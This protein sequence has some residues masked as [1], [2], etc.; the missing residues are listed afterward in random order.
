[1]ENKKIAIIDPV[2]S[3]AG[4]NYYDIGLLS[5]LQKLNIQTY[6][7]SNFSNAG[8]GIICHNI[9]DSFI[10]NK[11]KKGI[12]QLLAHFKAYRICR[13]ENIQWVI[14][15][16]FSV[17][18]S[19]LI[20][21]FLSRLFNFK[22][23]LIA[24][25]VDSLAGDD[26][27]FF[28]KIIYKFLN[29]HVVVHNKYSSQKIS[30]IISAE[31]YSQIQQGAY[32]HLVNKKI[33]Q[34]L[35]KEKLGFDKNTHY[36]LFFGQI[37]KLKRLD[38]LI[39]SMSYVDKKIKLVI[40]GKPWKDDFSKYQKLIEENKLENKIIQQIGFVN[41]NDRELLMKASDAIIF[42]YEEVYQSAALLMGMSYGLA[43]IVSDI[44]PFK[45]II[46]ENKN[47]LFFK[48][49]DS[50]DLAKKI[51]FLFKDNNLLNQLK[52]GS[53]N[54][55]NSELSWDSIAFKYKKIFNLY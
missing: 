55:I 45:E 33:T 11:L 35:A 5:G 30:K 34:S 40:A 6:L 36:V 31:K 46:K 18:L 1:M 42:P 41:D 4:M 48:S 43:V 7:F 9:F 15:H 14:F 29:D 2:G 20:F 52:K 19:T 3:K 38:I 16:V 25:D 50:I 51:N 21:C 53:L 8:N 12:R 22:T 39:N 28:K 13:K 23:L 49:L 44:D 32:P 27:K 47:G 24:H 26:N 37:K 54:S 17:K 10:K